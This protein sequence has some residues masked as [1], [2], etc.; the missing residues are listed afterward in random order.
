MNT[1]LQSG[2][3]D[4]LPVAEVMDTLNCTGSAE[5]GHLPFQNETLRSG[6]ASDCLAAQSQ[7]RRVFTSC[8]PLSTPF[9]S[10]FQ[11]TFAFCKNRR[12]VTQQFVF[13][14]HVANGAV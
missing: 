3:I 2:V 7:G 9:A 4:N 8:L 1:I 10:C 11:L 14:S 5:N 6:R 13:G 12:L